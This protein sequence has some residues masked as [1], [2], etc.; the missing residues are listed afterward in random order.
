M[1]EEQ[2][3]QKKQ[4]EEETGRGKEERIDLDN[5]LMENGQCP[6]NGDDQMNLFKI[7]MSNR[8]RTSCPM[9]I[10]GL[11]AHFHTSFH[12][13]IISDCKSL[14]PLRRSEISHVFLPTFF[15]THVIYFSLYIT[16]TCTLT[17]DMNLHTLS[18][19]KG[20]FQNEY[21]TDINTINTR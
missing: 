16:L 6:L 21:I 18:H 11:G 13:R 8:C 15:I 1:S 5:A 19:T 20:P 2:S 10:S 7:I 9:T 4:R 3:Q 12:I 14:N 17:Q